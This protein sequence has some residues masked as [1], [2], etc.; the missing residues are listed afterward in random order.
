MVKK[1]LVYITINL[2]SLIW[3]FIVANIYNIKDKYMDFALFIFATNMFVKF[4]FYSCAY[5]GKSKLINVSIHLLIMV[6]TLL[7]I[8]AMLDIINPDFKLCLKYTSAITFTVML[9]LLILFA[10]YEKN[11]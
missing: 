7:L 3:C 2:L 4:I 1:S 5:Y 6:T 8:I 10:L 11:Y 9:F